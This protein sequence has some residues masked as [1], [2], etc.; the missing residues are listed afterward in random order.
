MQRGFP[1]NHDSI[2]DHWGSSVFRRI[3]YVA[4]RTA[5][6]SYSAAATE[7]L[8][9]MRRSAPQ[10][11]WPITSLASARILAA[12]LS[13]NAPEEAKQNWIVIHLRREVMKFACAEC[14]GCVNSGSSEAGDRLLSPHRPHDVDSY[15]FSTGVTLFGAPERIPNWADNAN[16]TQGRRTVSFLAASGP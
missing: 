10:I 12:T 16:S 5:N 13:E 8:C 11:N 14:N 3:I 2:S 4:I 7:C 15:G 6:D 9:S 1:L